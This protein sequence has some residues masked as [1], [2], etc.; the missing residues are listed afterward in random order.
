MLSWRTNLVSRALESQE[1]LFVPSG[2]LLLLMEGEKQQ[3]E[4][5]CYILL[6]FFFFN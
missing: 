2:L 5:S 1:D 4:Q 3:G 6:F